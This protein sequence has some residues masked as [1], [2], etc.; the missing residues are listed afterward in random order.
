MCGILGEFACNSPIYE[1]SFTQ[2]DLDLLKHRG[3]DSNGWYT[4]K[5]CM[6]GFRRLAIIDRD[7]GDQPLYN[8]D[9]SVVLTVNGEIY[10]YKELKQ[11]LASHHH[12][13]SKV[14]G[15]VLIHLYEEDGEK[16]L[17]SVNGMFA[18]ALYD[19]KKNLLILGRDRAGKKP[20]YYRYWQ[21]KLLW[22]SELKVLT[23]VHLP[24]VNRNALSD[25]FRFGYVPAPLTI[26][27]GIFKLPASTISYIEF[28]KSIRTEPYWNLQYNY[29][30][31]EDPG[32][33]KFKER[34]KE[35]LDYFDSSVRNRLE[36]EVPIG[37]LLSGGIDSASVYASGARFLGKEKTLAFT[38][39]FADSNVDESDRAMDVVNQ[40]GGSHSILNLPQGKS[41]ALIDAIALTE[42]PVST[43]ALLPTNTV[44]NGIGKTNVVTVLSGEG[45]D[46]IFAGYSK[47]RY[48]APWENKNNNDDRS[49]LEKYLAHEEFVF[50]NRH[51]R[52]KLL[53]GDYDLNRFNELEKEAAD[54]D[55]LSQMLLFETK[56]RL[57]DRI[58]L[59][60][61]RLSMAY[62]IEARAPFMDFRFMEFCSK[63]PHRF[64]MSPDCDKYI[65]RQAMSTRLPRSVLQSKKTPFHAPQKWFTDSALLGK[66][67]S[68]EILIH[69]KLVN[70]EY[71]SNLKDMANSKYSRVVCEKLYSLFVLHLWH[72]NTYGYF[73]NVNAERTLS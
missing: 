58:N 28:G 34:Q 46:E 42:E 22:A 52:I 41:D 27:D 12:F 23:K 13:L 4:S 44:F 59:R 71:V 31:W 60:L 56:L 62:S 26:F 51:E 7:G 66:I 33:S 5:Y 53:N 9:R 64:I 65:L 63:L 32:E 11:G 55:Y 10:N 3:P 17:S 16:M 47:F 72:A 39:G 54:L 8:E 2:G 21:G 67:L 70:P 24:Q 20:L 37:F 45:A 15:E 50:S 36:S 14:D 73:H 38:V 6:M 69:A 40:C 29:D 68:H 49:P 43:D 1:F 30:G 61:D 25:Y 48:A 18:F 35:L 57:P 19:S